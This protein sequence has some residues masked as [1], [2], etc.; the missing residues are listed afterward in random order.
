LGESAVV[1]ELGNNIDPGVNQRVY[2]FAAAIERAGLQ[3][4]QEVVPTYRSLLVRYDP[5]RASF[6]DII[7]SLEDLARA[8]TA[9]TGGR[10]SRDQQRQLFEIPV[11]YGGDDGPDL[12]TVAQHAG[13]TPGEV[14]A[15]HTRPTYRVYMLGF[16]PGFPY[17]GGLDPR[18]ACPRLKTPR[19]RVPAG[20]VGIAENQTGVYPLAT[21]GGWQIIGRTPAPLFNPSREPPVALMPGSFLRFVQ[22]SSR[23]A[24]DI[25]RR[26]ADGR[27]EIP[28][29]RRGF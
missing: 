14:I 17:L 12:A 3:V 6:G 19:T 21:P 9:G 13:V 2:E 18:I 23:E 24:E 28:T 1:V 8:G 7:R 16:A 26:V 29:R 10:G 4:V 11:A 15:I 22:V 20:S 27:Y 25:A 5:L